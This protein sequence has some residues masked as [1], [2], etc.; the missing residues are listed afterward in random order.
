MTDVSF[1]SDRLGRAWGYNSA[2]GESCAFKVAAGK[3]PKFV[4]RDLILFGSILACH[5]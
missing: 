3:L 4:T 5:K 1:K 2:T